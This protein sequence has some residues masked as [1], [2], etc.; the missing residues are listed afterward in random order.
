MFRRLVL[1]FLGVLIFCLGGCGH[2]KQHQKKITIWIMPNTP[3]P[4]RDLEKLV[5]GFEL[6]N[7][8]IDVEVAVIDW[9]SAYSK[10]TTA[11]T[12]QNGPDLLQMPASWS[13]ALTEM[14]AL[15]ALD[16][17]LDVIG[18]DEKFPEAMMEYARPRAS[19]SVTSLPWFVDVRPLYYRKDVLRELHINPDHIRTWFDFRKVLEKIR[20]AKP[21]VEGIP[22]EPLGY[23]GKNDWNIIHNFA[24]WIYGAG[25]DFFNEAATAS[26]LASPQS[27]QAILFYLDLVRDGYNNV[28]NLE[29]NTAQVSSDFDEGR[30]AFW[31]DATTKTIYLD[32]PQFLGGAGKSAAARNYA[33]MLPPS[34]P[35][36]AHRYFVGG[37]GLS[38]FKFSQNKREAIKLLEY[39]VARPEVQLQMS[40]VSAFL[41]ALKETWSHPFFQQNP[42]LKVFLQM[43]MRGRSYPSVHYWAEIETSILS[44]R[45]GNIFDLVTEA[46]PGHWPH[47]AIVREIRATEQEITRY[48]EQQFNKDPGLKKR[49]EEVAQ[50]RHLQRLQRQYGAGARRMKP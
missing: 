35:T 17:L 22:V 6:E 3:D 36:G 34:S 14:G 30:L 4:A 50:K 20:K 32:R 29:K 46:R 11:A 10:I 26:T 7:P 2:Q 19:D 15:I 1:S 13:A 33:C 43:V 49:L 48:I 44:R 21:V 23:P 38:V 25:G 40:R 37:S 41:P 27:I 31:L 28:R 42:N 8:G 24:P 5:R 45:F 16:S 9:G 47:D 12:A 39:L 18:G